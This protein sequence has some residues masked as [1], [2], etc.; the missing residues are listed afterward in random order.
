MFITIAV[1]VFLASHYLY[2]SH[3]HSPMLRPTGTVEKYGT[4]AQDALKKQ[5]ASVVTRLG[6]PE[7]IALFGTEARMNGAATWDADKD[8]I[9]QSALTSELCSTMCEPIIQNVKASL[10]SLREDAKK[11]T[12]IYDLSGSLDQRLSDCESQFPWDH[13]IEPK[14]GSTL[15]NDATAGHKPTSESI[16]GQFSHHATSETSGAN[17]WRTWREAKLGRWHFPPEV[18]GTEYGDKLLHLL[19]TCTTY[20]SVT[21]LPDPD[22]LDAIAEELSKLATSVRDH[23]RITNF[24]C[25]KP[26]DMSKASVR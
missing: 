17:P 12:L 14:E 7:L 2:Y 24:P 19:A 6:V 21:R 11:S 5:L 9:V 1:L 22:A 18:D 15:A 16:P 26:D 4:T 3:T 8:D 20:K 23:K 13:G 10:D 25:S